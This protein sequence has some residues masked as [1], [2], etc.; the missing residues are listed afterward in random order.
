MPTDPAHRIPEAALA[1]V[2]G[3]ATLIG[4]EEREGLDGDVGKVHA[5]DLIEGGGGD[6]RL[7]GWV[8]DD[9]LKGQAGGDDLEG[10]VGDDRL[11]GGDGSD[12][13]M[14]EQDDDTL[15]GGAGDDNLNGGRGF[16]YMIGGDGDDRLSSR[17][18]G[19]SRDRST[20]VM[21]GGA[22]NDEFLVDLGGEW[23]YGGSDFALIDGGSGHDTVVVNTHGREEQARNLLIELLTAA[24]VEHVVE[25]DGSV[26]LIHGTSSSGVGDERL[27]FIAAGIERIRFA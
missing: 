4:T 13:L 9:T 19:V 10:F 22:G 3:G 26:T 1:A 27:G 7:R 17:Y 25:P 5:H 21:E 2:S 8:G 16:D 24:Q 23:S 6:D 12:W 18:D 15:D 20:D 14:G 11:E